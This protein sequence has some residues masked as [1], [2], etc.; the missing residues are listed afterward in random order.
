[1]SAT[2]PTPIIEDRPTFELLM[3]QLNEPPV[4]LAS[5]APWVPPEAARLVMSCLSKAPDERPALTDLASRFGPIVAALPA[6]EQEAAPRRVLLR[7]GSVDA[8]GQTAAAP[9]ATPSMVD[10]QPVSN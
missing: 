8:H 3:R 7:A 10:T 5:I 4:E 6:S 9:V 1:T 2:W